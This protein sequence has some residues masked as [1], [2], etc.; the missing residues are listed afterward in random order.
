MEKSILLLH[1]MNLAGVVSSATGMPKEFLTATY[2][3]HQKFGD[4]VMSQVYANADGIFPGLGA[5]L[6]QALRTYQANKDKAKNQ[7]KQEMQAVLTVGALVAAPFTV[8]A[9]LE[10]MMAVDAAQGAIQGMTTLRLAC[11]CV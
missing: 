4:A 7:Q 5:Q 2:V 1:R 10:V 3:N 6:G 11:N 9:S 8:G